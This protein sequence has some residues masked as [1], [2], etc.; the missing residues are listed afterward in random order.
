M[1]KVWIE[2]S[3]K[4]QHKDL[5]LEIQ[6][7]GLKVVADTYY[8]ILDD[9]INENRIADFFKNL[10]N[11]IEKLEEGETCYLPFDFSDQYIGCLQVHSDDET[12]FVNYGFTTKYSGTNIQPSDIAEFVV[13]SA[14]EF[15]QT[16]ETITTSKQ[17]L[18][19]DFLSASD[20][21]TLE[22]TSPINITRQLISAASVDVLWRTH[23]FYD[24]LELAKN[25]GYTVSYW[26]GEE[27]WA[28]I[29]LNNKIITFVWH[30]YPLVFVNSEGLNTTNVL[31]NDF[32]FL[33]V[34]K[35]DNFVE[36]SLIIDTE[37]I[38]QFGLTLNNYI[39]SVED[40][41]FYN[42]SR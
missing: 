29:S 5:H 13:D 7:I 14:L 37:V 40:F 11:T 41:W 18:I 35:V 31:L 19:A 32:N 24:F 21:N 12:V 8:F 27:D 6:S 1:L 26:E 2:Y 39:F 10:S 28:A 34:I 25:I 22:K 23:S 17:E 20:K 4:S 15:R 38:N 30:I 33:V 9:N 16:S 42:N 3:N 36:Q